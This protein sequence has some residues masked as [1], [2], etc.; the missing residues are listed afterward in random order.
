MS[1]KGP[2]KGPDDPR[3]AAAVKLRSQAPS[4]SIPQVMRAAN[5][6]DEDSNNPTCQMWV[7]RRIAKQKDKQKDS[8]IDTTIDINS[9]GTTISSITTPSSNTTNEPKHPPPKAKQIRR[10]STQVQQARADNKKKTNHTKEARK[11]ATRMYAAEKDKVDGKSAEK[12]R[13]ETIKEFGVA[14]TARTIG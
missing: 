9:P 13:E 2:A 10:N 12:V 14:P 5:F 1:E 11:F 3:V 4:F 8:A 7:R 6:T